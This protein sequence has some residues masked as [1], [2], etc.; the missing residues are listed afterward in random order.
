MLI[1]YPLRN[2]Q[3]KQPIIVVLFRSYTNAYCMPGQQAGEL[4]RKAVSVANDKATFHPQVNLRLSIPSPSP[5]RSSINP[6][7]SIIFTFAIH[8]G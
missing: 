5:L 2:N 8:H 4:Y 6:P 3:L 1:I 7:T